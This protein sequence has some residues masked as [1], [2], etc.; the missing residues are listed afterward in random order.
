MRLICPNCDAQY[1]V[2]DDV[3]PPEGRDVQCSNCAQTWFQKHPDAPPPAATGSAAQPKP[4]QSTDV[5]VVTPPVEESENDEANPV[6]VS[7]D[8][9]PQT[10][11]PPPAARKK[12][13]PTV[14]NVLL[15]E[16]EFEVKARRNENAGAVE[17]QPDLGLDETEGSDEAR[18]RAHDARERKAR[19]R[20]EAPVAEATAVASDPKSRQR[21]VLPNI[22]EINSTLRSNSDRSP[23]DDPGQTAQVEARERRRFGNGFFL[24]ALLGAALA[25]TYAFAPQLAQAVPQLDPWITKYVGAVDQWRVWLDGQ[26]SAILTWLDAVT[27]SSQ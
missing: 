17:T 21:T 3:M 1:D 25:L 8:P 9:D 2:P 13:D 26:V 14:I 4:P 16:A 23:S 12:L 5:D 24:M 7:E 20:S 22:D 18:K 11:P 19:K 6:S 15:E 27:A 10:P